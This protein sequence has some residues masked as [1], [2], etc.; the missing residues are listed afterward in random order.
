M[1]FFPSF[2]FFCCLLLLFILPYFPVLNVAKSSLAISCLSY[3]RNSFI[4]HLSSISFPALRTVYLFI[5]LLFGVNTHAY[6]G[7]TYKIKSKVSY[8]R[9]QKQN[10]IFFLFSLFMNRIKF[11]EWKNK[12]WR[13]VKWRTL[14]PIF[15]FQWQ[16]WTMN[17]HSRL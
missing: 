5:K 12:K 10:W 1:G 6:H 13:C 15:Y 4:L 11:Q 9:K 7:I 2:F 14:E 17:R 8:S 16:W 3:R